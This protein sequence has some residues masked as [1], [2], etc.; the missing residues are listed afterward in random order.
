LDQ[1]AEVCQGSA[2]QVREDVSPL[3]LRRTNKRTRACIVQIRYIHR[4]G[5]PDANE[6]GWKVAP[7][8]GFKVL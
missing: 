8:I 7:A 3:M 4:I 2:C 1:P 5:D 6:S